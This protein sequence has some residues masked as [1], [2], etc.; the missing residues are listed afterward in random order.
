MLVILGGCVYSIKKCWPLFFAPGLTF[1]PCRFF[2]DKSGKDVTL[3]I[4]KRGRG[5]PFRFR[6]L[7]TASPEINMSLPVNY[8]ENHVSFSIG[9]RHGKPYRHLEGALLH[10]PSCHG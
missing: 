3:I 9:E 2:L 1:R 10:R 7:K 5:L 8:Q 6:R 4:A